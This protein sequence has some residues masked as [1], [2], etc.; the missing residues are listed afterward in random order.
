MIPKTTTMRALYVHVV[1]NGVT[2]QRI[3][4]DIVKPRPND[5]NMPTQHVATLLGATCC[6]CLASLLGYVPTCWMLLAQI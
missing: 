4:Y 6:V 2:F 1:L 5:R 3:S